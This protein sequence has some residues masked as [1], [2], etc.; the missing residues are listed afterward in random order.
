[1]THKIHQLVACSL[2]LAVTVALAPVAA[3]SD[4][5]PQTPMESV[6]DTI[7]DVIH[8]LTDEHL[9]QPER[10]TERRQEIERLI[11]DRVSYGEMAKQALGIQWLNLA[12]SER[13]GK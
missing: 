8:I 5:L 10:L 12:D 11:R 1:M 7:E 13:Q 2:V 3:A 6:R 4:S 9:K